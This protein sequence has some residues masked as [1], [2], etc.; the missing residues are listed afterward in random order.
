M[1]LR[2]WIRQRLNGDLHRIDLV[3]PGPVEIPPPARAGLQLEAPPLTPSVSASGTGVSVPGTSDKPR[4]SPRECAGS[5]L[6]TTVLYPP[7]SAHA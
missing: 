5:V 3:A 1:G 6:T 2:S 4:A 7:C